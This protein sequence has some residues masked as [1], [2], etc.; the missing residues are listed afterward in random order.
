MGEFVNYNA[1]FF[2]MDGSESELY[3]LNQVAYDFLVDWWIKAPM[4]ARIAV[5]SEDDEGNW[6]PGQILVKHEQIRFVD[7]WEAA[8]EVQ[9]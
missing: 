8:E 3:R 2:F 7:T 4:R 5:C 6:I 1:V 9:S